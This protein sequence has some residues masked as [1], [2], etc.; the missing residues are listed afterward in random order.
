MIEGQKE[1]LINRADK[2]V[3]KLQK[4]TY[5]SVDL[6]NVIEDTSYALSRRLEGENRRE[7]E[8]NFNYIKH[9]NAL[10][11]HNEEDNFYELAKALIVMLE[12]YKDFVRTA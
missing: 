11:Y 12:K 8:N 3:L 7:W 5:G 1:A 2:F 9:D 4:A 6:V 10:A